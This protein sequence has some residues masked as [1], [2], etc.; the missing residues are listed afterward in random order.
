MIW[1]YQ[2][3]SRH[4]DFAIFP[5]DV[6]FLVQNPVEDPVFHLVVFPLSPSTCDSS[7]ILLCLL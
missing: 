1:Y 5:T 7:S 2:L 6:L 4:S 3:I